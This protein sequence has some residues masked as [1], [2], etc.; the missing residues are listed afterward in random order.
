M[1]TL[2]DHI[3]PDRMY[4]LRSRNKQPKQ[5]SGR[6]IVQSARSSTIGRFD[7]L[8][9]DGR[10]WVRAD[11]IA[12]LFAKRQKR[13]SRRRRS[14]PTETEVEQ[15]NEALVTDSNVAESVNE[16]PM[17]ADPRSQQTNLTPEHWMIARQ[18]LSAGPYTHA[19]LIEWVSQGRLEASDHVLWPGNPEWVTVH[20]AQKRGVLPQAPTQERASAKSLGLASVL[21][22]ILGFWL[23]PILGW[24]LGVI[25]GH[26]ALDRTRKR[27]RARGRTSARLGL[28]IGYLGICL[29]MVLLLLLCIAT[30]LRPKTETRF[31]YW[32]SERTEV[33]QE[34]TIVPISSN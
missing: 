9:E 16:S 4:W 18:G 20:E 13:K 2:P 29:S 19:Q 6:L 27:P 24:Y 3:D 8:S 1:N 10:I 34:S 32:Y 30:L 14:L 28:T 15:N 33:R 5:M 25:C 31:W 26:M 12:T 7:E 22:S 23:L 21:F 17:V 11:D